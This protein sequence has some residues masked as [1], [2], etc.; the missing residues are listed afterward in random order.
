MGSRLMI[1]LDKL[2]QGLVK[3]AL[4][5]LCLLCGEPYLETGRFRRGEQVVVIYECKCDRDR[6]ERIR[7]AGDQRDPSRAPLIWE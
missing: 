1:D 7:L 5:Q 4:D 3:E 2:N 6:A